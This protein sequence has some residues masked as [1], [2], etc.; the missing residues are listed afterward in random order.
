[1]PILPKTL[2]MSSARRRSASW[3][4]Q[5][6]P[7]V[8][9][10]VAACRSAGLLWQDAGKTVPATASGD[11]VRVAVCPYSGAEWT[12]ASDGER[13][14]LFNLNPGV[15]GL[16]GNET[17]SLLSTPQLAI[18]TGVYYWH[19]GWQLSAPPANRFGAASGAPGFIPQVN[20]TTPVITDGGTF[21]DNCPTGPISLE[22][23][24][25][26]G[27]GSDHANSIFRMDGAS[28]G[29]NPRAKTWL[30]IDPRLPERWMTTAILVI[31]RL[32]TAGEVALIETW[33]ASQT[34]AP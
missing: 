3:N 26:F 14:Q 19:A 20:S 16:Q 23:P 22:L 12:A 24:R 6:L 7:V 15:W 10:P 33:L 28:V 31:P 2:A 18:T 21:T 9:L 13:M 25:V 29:S 30:T 11:P 17:N 8:T 4:P 5:G 1:M 27:W 32:P 34:P